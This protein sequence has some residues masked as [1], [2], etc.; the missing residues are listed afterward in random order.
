MEI[1]IIAN[2]SL[3]YTGI[4]R[5]VVSYVV[6][7]Y[8]YDRYDTKTKLLIDSDIKSALNIVWKVDWQ[9]ISSFESDKIIFKFIIKPCIED[10]SQVLEFDLIYSW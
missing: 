9:M 5:E 2:S 7:N 10:E 3:S 6:D 8:L 1:K 4:A